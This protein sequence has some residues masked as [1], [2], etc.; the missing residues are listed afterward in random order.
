MEGIWTVERLF[1]PYTGPYLS[2]NQVGIEV[3][4]YGAS[5][6]LLQAGANVCLPDQN[7]QTPLHYAYRGDCSFLPEVAEY[8]G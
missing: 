6:Y 1:T 7:G 5:Q 2:A 3:E 8:F 4:S